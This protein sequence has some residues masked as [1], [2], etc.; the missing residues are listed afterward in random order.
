VN[1]ET[2]VSL[3]LHDNE[4]V[5]GQSMEGDG[6]VP[7]AFAELTGTKT[8]YIEESHGSLPNNR[9]VAQATIELLRQG[10]TSLLPQQWAPVR[11]SPTRTVREQ[12]L[13][14]PA[15]GGRKGKEVT[16]QEIRHALDG[17]VAP[18]S[19]D[20]PD[21][22]GAGL[23]TG[24]VQPNLHEQPLNQ[25]IVGRRRQHR[26][27]IRLALGS[28]TELDTRAY[29]LGIYRNVTP[30]GPAEA[31]DERMDGAIK[32]F[33]T[34]RMFGGNVGEVFVMPTGRHP[35][36]ADFIIFAGLGDFDRFSDTV[37]QVCAENIV[38]I[39][40]RT[41]VE[42]FGTVL[43]GGGS[44]QDIESALQD[45][46]SGFFRALKDT[47]RDHWFRRITICEWNP[48]RYQDIRST[49]LR[50][51]ST[52][53]F[54]DVEVTFDEVQLRSP[55][56]SSGPRALKGPEPAYLLVRQETPD[57][58][59][60]TI[61]FT[62]SVLTSGSKASVVTDTQHVTGDALDKQLAKLESTSLNLAT[63]TAFGDELAQLVLPERVRAVLGQ[64]KNQHLVVVHDALS[65]RI[66]WETLQVNGWAPAISQGVSRRYLATNLSVA[67]WL[68][69]RQRAEKLKLLLVVNP[70]QDL[71]GAEKEGL[72][73]NKLFKSYP[74]VVIELVHG[75][76]ATK[77][78]LLKKFQ[79]GAYDVVHYAGHAFF[80]P[81]VP[82]RSGILCHGREVLNGADLAGI[83][84]LPSLVFFNACE[85]ARVR[86]P[87]EKKNRA[88]NIDERVARSAGLAEAFLLGGVANYVG[89]YWPVGDAAA[90]TFAQTFYTELLRQ[91][92]IGMA[93]LAG[94]QEVQTK[95]KSIDWADYIHYGSYDFELKKT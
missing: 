26:L 51:A 25:V 20:Q 36:Q 38:R 37:L 87:A 7:K 50:L 75:P 69:Q 6:T 86:K 65:S 42:E 63:L 32:E 22:S 10:D 19:R 60:G 47:D 23:V 8:Y 59:N 54:E 85:A 94:R 18:D 91:K 31:L 40:I 49:L 73:I 58:D 83:G 48:R 79:S 4:F 16:D 70:T 9:L 92:T 67:K 14:T 1:Q 62:S 34:R 82:A 52:P 71:E 53:L 30:S 76:Q 81:R 28:I 57:Q 84:N 13:R 15:Y 11:R 44:G 74:S 17:F 3:K 41:S 89:T 61:S 55:L 21:Q 45:L 5:Y 24:M 90:E 33:T 77:A 2:V 35:L 46:L 29:V 39:C 66:P 88:L 72:R 27:D 95:L 80:D 56:V 68:E 93:L 43:M 12:T 64:M 78:T